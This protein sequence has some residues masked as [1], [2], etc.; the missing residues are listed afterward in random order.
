MTIHIGYLGGNSLFNIDAGCRLLLQSI[1]KEDVEELL[2]DLKYH[3][4]VLSRGENQDDIDKALA[5]NKSVKSEYFQKI[6]QLYAQ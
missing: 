2:N 1:K 3:R 4:E 5:K 6:R